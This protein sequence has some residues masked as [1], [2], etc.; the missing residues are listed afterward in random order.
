MRAGLACQGKLACILPGRFVRRKKPGDQPGEAP[1]FKSRWCVRGDQDPDL[2]TLARAAPTVTTSSLMVV[3]QLAASRQMPGTIGDL[4]KAFMQSDRL[5]R[6]HGKLY[7]DHTRR[8]LKGLVPGQLVEL[9]SGV[10][11]LGDAPLHFR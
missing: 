5:Q 10:Y 6:E 2:L 8:G 7:A 1:S 9:V 4:W 11:G 3:L